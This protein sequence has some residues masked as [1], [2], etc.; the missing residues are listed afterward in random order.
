MNPSRL[1]EKVSRA[2]PPSRAPSLPKGKEKAQRKKW[3]KNHPLKL[4]RRPLFIGV[5]DEEITIM[6]LVVRMYEQAPKQATRAG[7]PAS[8][9]TVVDG[10]RLV[11]PRRGAGGPSVRGSSGWGFSWSLAAGRGGGWLRSFVELEGMFLAL[12]I[13]IARKGKED[14]DFQSLPTDGTR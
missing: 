8:A 2:S 12:A 9:M 1:P 7:S 3:A 10:G 5:G 13:L 4:W 6:P 11:V 14:D